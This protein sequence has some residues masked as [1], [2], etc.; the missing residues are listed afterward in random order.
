M[1]TLKKTFKHIRFLGAEGI[2]MSALIKILEERKLLGLENPEMKISK[3]DISYEKND[4]LDSDIDLVVCSTAIPESDLEFVELKKRGLEFWHRSDMLQ[5][6]AK[7]YKEI[8]VSGTHGKTTCSAMI[9]YILFENHLD[10]AFAV[11]GLILKSDKSRD[12][13]NSRAGLGEYFVLEGDESDKSFMKSSPYIALVTSIEP[14]HLENYPG[15]LDEIK[16]CFYEFL[17]KAAWRVI[18]LDNDL[19]ANYYANL[20]EEKKSKTK[21]YKSSELPSGIELKIPGKHNKLNAWAAILVCEI[22]GVT[23]TESLKSLKNFKG[24]KRRFELI[25]NSYKSPSGAS[26]ILVYDDYA[27][28]P[29]EL[30][31]LIDSALELFPERR[32][33]IVYQPHHPERTKQFW[34]EF[35]KVISEIPEQHKLFLADIY[36]ARSK[37][38]EGIESQKMVKEINK[39]NIEYLGLD[40]KTNLNDG[41][42]NDKE[43]GKKLKPIIDK[44]LKEND[45]LMIVG[46]GSIYKLAVEFEV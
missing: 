12:G 8:V 28:H 38:I 2:G 41:L 27:H 37:P 33:I 6:L 26:N 9:S 21:I 34:E 17:D 15:G 14:D 39:T 7:D 46:A 16:N 1:K 44:Q 13:F 43:I 19:L 5:S 30:K 32:M 45:L 11:G 40:S 22:V 31:A 23:H 20:N 4:P 10:P 24:I 25:N 35:K 42:G 3:S 29:S 36:V 18:C